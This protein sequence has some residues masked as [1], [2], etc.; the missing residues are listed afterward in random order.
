MSDTEEQGDEAPAV[1]PRAVQSAEVGLQYNI[2]I[3]AEKFRCA[4]ACASVCSASHVQSAPSG[5]RP[6]KR[7]ANNAADGRTLT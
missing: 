6:Q 4:C 2:S 5:S 3:K 1:Q 7:A